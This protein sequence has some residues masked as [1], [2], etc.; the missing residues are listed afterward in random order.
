VVKEFPQGYVH[1]LVQRALE[2]DVGT[3]D[4][5]SAATVPESTVARAHLVAKAA[6]V[7]SGVDVAEATFLAI[8]P[9]IRFSTC[10]GEGCRVAKGDLVFTVEGRARA[11]LAAERTALNFLAHLSGVATLTARFVDAVAGSGAR[12]LDTR[13]TTPGMRL[14]E[15]RAVRSGGGMNHRVGL[16]DMVLMK[17]N[18]IRAAGGITK[19][20]SACNQYLR[21]QGLTGTKVEVE[22][23][24]EEE[25]REA[26][27]AGC[28]RIMLDNM[29]EDEMRSSVLL[30]RSIAPAT[31]IEASGNMTLERVPA[32]AKTGVDFIS[33]GALTHSAPVLD[34]SLQFEM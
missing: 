33:I 27:A 23:T 8:D 28:D 3:G 24:C 22:T 10:A 18:H 17:E 11:L 20:I 15:K 14:L 1:A 19:A 34:L 31:E 16:Y 4:I 12:I 25:V 26:L 21:H 13:K 6:G 2:E 5:T 7:L 29:T 30:I 32:V 9:G